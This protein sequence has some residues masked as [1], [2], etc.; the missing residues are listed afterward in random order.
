[1][2]FYGNCKQELNYNGNTGPVCVVNKGAACTDKVLIEV[3]EKKAYLSW[4]ACNRQKGK[5]QF[6]CPFCV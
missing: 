4:E 1:M 2:T 6:V 5:Q 3:A